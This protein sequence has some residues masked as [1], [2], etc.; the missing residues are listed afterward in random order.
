MGS[1]Y[2]YDIET[3]QEITDNVDLFS[4]VSQS[5]EFEQK[6]EDYFANCPLHV[7]KTP[8]FSITPRKNRY[9]CFSCLRS[10]GIISYLV[11]Y[12]HMPFNKAVEKAAKLANID[13]SKLC[14][15]KTVMFLKRVRSLKQLKMLPKHEVLNANELSKY[16]HEKIPEWESEGIKPEVMD[17]FGVMANNRDNRIVY[18][19]Y[20]INSNLINI[21]GRTR[22]QNY[23]ALKIPKYINYYPVGVIDYFQGLNITLPYVLEAGEII[24]FESVKSVMK[25]YGWG[26]RNTASAEKHTL[27][28]E[29]IKLLV[30]LHVDIVLAFDTDVDYK[31]KSLKE[32]INKLKH[33]ANVYLIKDRK[34]L[35][36]GKQTKNSPVDLTKEIWEELYDSKSKQI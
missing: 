17:L 34:R 29:Q 31:E 24:I 7:D 21:K 33:V 9:Y 6:G 30:G 12:E 22:Y 19:V 8:S 4:Y 14:K 5:M 35:L 10:G 27:T 32:S 18:P 26:Y 20:D 23:K 1:E 28:D 2:K 36:G 25:A 11:D 13:M 3:L 15:S 16:S